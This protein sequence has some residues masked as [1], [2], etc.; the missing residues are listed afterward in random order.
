MKVE[1]ESYTPR[2]HGDVIRLASEVFGAGYFDRPS[3][4]ATQ[5]GSLVLVCHEDDERLV[6][7]A[8]GQLLSE[9]RLRDYLGPRVAEVP[10]EIAEADAQGALGAIQAVAV[11]P[12]RRRRGIGCKLLATLHD[13]L[14][15]LGADKLIITFRRG[16]SA[17]PVDGLM[18]RLDFEPWTR[19]P[20][21][22]QERCESGA[23][24]CVDRR[25]RCACEAVF[26]RKKVF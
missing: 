10:A 6:G 1:I 17:S 25:D 2:W 19:L 23:F 13:A 11:L 22:W 4:I 20:T 16:P 24:K 9:G 8:Q 3:E 14:V 12:G 26:Y 21:Y 15:G 18:A 5:P 7:F